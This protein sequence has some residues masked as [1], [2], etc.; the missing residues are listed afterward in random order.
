MY[1]VCK[2]S[3]SIIVSYMSKWVKTTELY[4]GIEFYGQNSLLFINYYEIS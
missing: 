2:F 1:L 3:R 4:T